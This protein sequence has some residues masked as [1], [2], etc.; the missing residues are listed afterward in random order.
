MRRYLP[1]LGLLA[2]GVALY[3]Y[4]SIPMGEKI[5]EPHPTDERGLIQSKPSGKTAPEVSLP[6]TNPPEAK[7]AQEV[8][9]LTAKLFGDVSVKSFLQAWQ[10]REKSQV[11]YLPTHARS[12]TQVMALVPPLS[13]EEKTKLKESISSLI[14]ES[15]SD[16]P[17]ADRE[18][19]LG[20]VLNWI[21]PQESERVI[22]VSY[23]LSTDHKYESLSGRWFDVVDSTKFKDEYFYMDFGKITADGR[24][25][26]ER[27]MER[28]GYLFSV[29]E[30]PV[31]Q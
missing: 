17:P 18:V 7:S 23:F 15:F 29:E 5:G 13:A 25:T 11:R 14:A 27:L 2:F 20:E 10:A 8:A 9:D 26:K 28:Y 4:W 24:L 19:M 16:A 21:A 30:E 12:G 31:Q 6:M 3:F 22:E 1:F